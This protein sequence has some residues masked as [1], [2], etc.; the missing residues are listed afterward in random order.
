MS[1]KL[2]PKK[3]LVPQ[4]GAG[5]MMVDLHAYL[6][7]AL[8]SAC[9]KMLD[10]AAYCIDFRRAHGRATTWEGLVEHFKKHQ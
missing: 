9:P 5:D 8:G 2:K 1:K 4:A 7:T 3:T 10:M 6:K